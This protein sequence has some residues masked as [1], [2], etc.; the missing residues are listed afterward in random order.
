MKNNK[1]EGEGTWVL[2]NGEKYEGEF[3]NNMVD[4]YGRF[5]GIKETVEGRWKENLLVEV[6]R[7]CR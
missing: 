4:G 6:F 1:K 7:T 2:E 5:H 3:H